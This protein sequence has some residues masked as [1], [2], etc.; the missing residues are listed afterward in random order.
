[1]FTFNVN[2]ELNMYVNVSQ[3]NDFLLLNP[4]LLSLF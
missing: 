4:L 1:M 2:K 3:N